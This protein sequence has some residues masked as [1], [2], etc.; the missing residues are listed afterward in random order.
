MAFDFKKIL[1]F[2]NPSYAQLK[3]LL[4]ASVG[5]IGIVW[6]ISAKTSEFTSQTKETNKLTKEHT[7]MI[8]DLKSEM[9]TKTDINN[10][11]INMVDMN[12]RNNAYL[13]SKFNLLINYG[14]SHKDLL[15]DMMKSLDEQQKLYDEDRLKNIPPVTN[16][17]TTR[18]Q[19]NIKVIP[20][21]K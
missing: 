8:K 16:P 12:T 2:L 11:Y 18:R 14:N 15:L 4:L 3:G 10:L 5:T 20:I 6:F 9:A 7:E 17:D 1:D 21:K 19:Y 13:N